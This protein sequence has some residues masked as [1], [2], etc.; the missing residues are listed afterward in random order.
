MKFLGSSE[1]ISQE[2]NRLIKNYKTGSWAV[3]WASMDF[4][5][6]KIFLAH[7]EKFERIIIGIH[8]YQT[9]PNFIKKV[10]M[11]RNIRFIMNPDGVFHPKLYLFEN[12]SM[13]WECIIGSP[14]FTKFAFEKNSEVA[15]LISNKDVGSDAAYKGINRTIDNY[16]KNAK[17]ITKDFLDEYERVSKRKAPLLGRLSGHYDGLVIPLKK[18][19]LEVAIFKMTWE[20]Y[21]SEV[22][23]DKYYKERIKLINSARDLF[24]KHKHFKDIS[25][26]DRHKIAGLMKSGDGFDWRLFGSMIPA[27]DFKITIKDNNIHISQALEF[28]PFT[29]EITKTDYDSYYKEFKKAFPSG[30]Y[31]VATVTRLL[32]MKRPDYF[33][34]LNKKNRDKFSEEFGITID[35][36]PDNYW[37]TVVER[38][39]DCFWWESSKPAEK[40][41][42]STWNGRA[43][44]LDSLFYKE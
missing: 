41:E 31:H 17:T 44:L 30:G 29:G 6:N 1:I 39:K 37:S 20:K 21:F 10:I 7:K 22:K 12:N 28:I 25:S 23:K 3:A 2:I 33:L 5:S 34:C 4:E 18:S 42:E 11:D 15:I 43:S 13:E 24:K 26:D 36:Q 32:A 35:I 14:N 8:F 9:D 38:I 19:P 40:E 27:R 16:W